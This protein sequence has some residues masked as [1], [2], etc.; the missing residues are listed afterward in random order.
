M[1]KICGV[2][3][4]VDGKN[5]KVKICVQVRPVGIYEI[6]DGDEK[7]QLTVDNLKKQVRDIKAV[8]MQ[9]VTIADNIREKL[10]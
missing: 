9:D 5:T 8:S 3:T 1:L 4:Y 6:L 10:Q 7:Q 2:T